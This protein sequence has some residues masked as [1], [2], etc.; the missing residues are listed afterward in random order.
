MA[1]SVGPPRAKKK[2]M[3]TSTLTLAASVP[4]QEEDCNGLTRA[5]EAEVSRR[6]TP[7]PIGS[8][9]TQIQPQ[10]VDAPLI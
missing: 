8:F 9:T 4:G 3:P 10:H 7:R 1:H 6:G 5:R 2:K